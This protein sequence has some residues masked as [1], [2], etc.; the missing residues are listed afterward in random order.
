MD[1]N[2]GG[3]KSFTRTQTSKQSIIPLPADNPLAS[4]YDISPS[5][6]NDCWADL[7]IKKY[8]ENQ[9]SPVQYQVPAILNTALS[10]MSSLKT[11]RGWYLCH[12]SRD[13][14]SNSM[15]DTDDV[16]PWLDSQCSHE[17]SAGGGLYNISSTDCLLQSG[18]TCSHFTRIVLIFNVTGLDITELRKGGSVTWNTNHPHS[19]QN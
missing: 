16:Q 10:A 19:S 7:E 18:C 3:N 12:S 2:K 6:V 9:S 4:C 8:K 14:R 11:E 15:N 13:S 17:W 5:R 1:C